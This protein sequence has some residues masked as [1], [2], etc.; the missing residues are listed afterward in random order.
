MDQNMS[1]GANQGY[2]F[3]EQETKDHVLRGCI[4]AII[5][6]AIAT[7]PW[8]LV[9]LFANRMLSILALLIAFGAWFGYQLLG[10]KKSVKMCIVIGV[11]TI[12]MLCL[13]M[14]VI[15]PL[16]MLKQAGYY[17]DFV[18]LQILYEDPDFF[19][20][21]MADLLVAVIFGAIGIAI[22]CRNAYDSEK[23]YRKKSMQNTAYNNP[24]VQVNQNPYQNTNMDSNVN[25]SQNQYIN[26]NQ[27]TN[28]Y[29]NPVANQNMNQNQNQNPQ[30]DS[31]NSYMNPDQK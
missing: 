26:Q 3:A 22:T 12:A 9:Y 5:G 21:S 30:Q 4:G 13:S 8:I 11:V 6:G 7:I 17:A 23:A 27:T 20:A 16:I 14:L 19:R 15:I 29:Q 24:Q 2:G 1:Q 10:G 18:N 31:W 28:Q 25:M